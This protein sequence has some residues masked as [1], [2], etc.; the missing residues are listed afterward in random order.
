MT[1]ADYRGR[2]NNSPSLF[3]FMA[4]YW[5]IVSLLL[6]ACGALVAIVQHYYRHR[7]DP[8][9]IGDQFAATL[10]EDYESEEL[11]ETGVRRWAVERYARIA[12]T[13]GL[14]ASCAD[15]IADRT[16]ERVS[17]ARPDMAAV[18]PAAMELYE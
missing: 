7:V 8:G 12:A 10:L 1:F 14:P 2:R 15:D 5:F 4:L 3:Y 6:V 18:A 9:R 17:A 11:N 13:F 16:W